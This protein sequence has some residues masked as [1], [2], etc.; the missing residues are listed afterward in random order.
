[1]EEGGCISSLVGEGGAIIGLMEG[2]DAIVRAGAIVLFASF[3][4]VKCTP[5]IVG[6]ANIEI[7]T[8][9]LSLYFCCLIISFFLY[10][11]SYH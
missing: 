9:T 1:M 11:Y 2:I 5:A 6:N 7:T 10:Y 8:T 4:Y 3:Y